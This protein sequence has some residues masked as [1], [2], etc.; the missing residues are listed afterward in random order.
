MLVPHGLE[1]SGRATEVGVPRREGRAGRDLGRRG[2]DPRDQG[3]EGLRRRL[4]REVAQGRRQDH[5]SSGCAAG[6]LRLPRRALDPP[7]HHEP[8][9]VD[10]RHRP[11][12]AAGHQGT[13]LEGGWGRDGVQADRVRTSQMARRQRTPSRRPRPRRSH[14]HQ[15]QTRR[16]TPRI[17]TRPA[18]RLTHQSTGIDYYSR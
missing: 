17:T 6:V 18:S 10:L 7:A 3:G 9:R 11:A 14:L 15:R 5:R 4:R 13:R 2:Q 12:A 8:D 1:R 16:T